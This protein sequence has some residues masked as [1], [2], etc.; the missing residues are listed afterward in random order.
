MRHTLKYTCL[1]CLLLI[2]LPSLV[3]GEDNQEG[4]LSIYLDV[5]NEIQ[6]VIKL[7]DSHETKLNDFDDKLLRIQNILE[8]IE[9]RFLELEKNLITAKDVEQKL[10]SFNTQV[11]QKLSSV[12]TNLMSS[13]RVQ[14]DNLK[15]LTDENSAL[16][17]EFETL[18]SIRED[19][20]YSINNTDTVNLNNAIANLF[21]TQ[22]L[23]IV[24]PMDTTTPVS[25]PQTIRDCADVKI[26]L[27][28]QYADGVHELQLPGFD[29]FNVYC[30]TKCVQEDQA[31]CC[32]WTVIQRNENNGVGKTTNSCWEYKNGVGN[33]NNDYFI[34]LD[35]LHKM[36]NL[37]R[38]TLLVGKSFQS[39]EYFTYDGFAIRDERYNYDVDTLGASWGHKFG[40]RFFSNSQKLKNVARKQCYFWPFKSLGHFHL[41]NRRFS[42]YYF[43]A[44]R[45]RICQ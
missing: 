11:E 40:A 41:F 15:K 18:T 17:E 42:N 2:L 34:G 12:E 10:Q 45:P 16:Q 20:C 33:A 35:R 9:K 7:V 44:I 3:Y 43:M 22:S 31:D 27:G 36:T 32:P 25:A 19:C 24:K 39:D 28:A 8:S 37:K 13:M 14:E 38:Q 26:K 21:P 4:S 6:N 29:A 1:G 5:G 23:A 30:L